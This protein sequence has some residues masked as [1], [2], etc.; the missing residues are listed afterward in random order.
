MPAAK[1]IT[2]DDLVEASALLLKAQVPAKLLV[3]G[4]SWD[5]FR[6]AVSEVV[7]A[8]VGERTVREA[9]EKH[10]GT[11]QR[12]AVALALAREVAESTHIARAFG[13]TETTIAKLVASES[14]QWPEDLEAAAIEIFANAVAA[15]PANGGVRLRLFLWT[16]QSDPTLAAALRDRFARDLERV[17]P[18][19]ASLLVRLDRQLRIPDTLGDLIDTLSALQDGFLIRH[20]VAPMGDPSGRPWAEK[21][22][23]AVVKMLEAFTE[24][25]N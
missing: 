19:Y 5:A 12:A 8:P 25:A 13:L 9:C 15:V 4:S 18:D 3:A 14:L 7:G 17:R 10:L 2:R 24:P 20:L 22:A 23:H 6:K 16:Q 21:F 11:Q 1:N